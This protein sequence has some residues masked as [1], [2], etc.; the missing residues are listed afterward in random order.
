M[1]SVRNEWKERGVVVAVKHR[2]ETQEM[3]TQIALPVQGTAGL[4]VVIG[5][6]PINLAENPSEVV[7]K[8]VIAYSF[9]EAQRQLGYSDDFKNYSLC[10]SMDA[11]FRIFSIAPIIFINVL[12]PEKHKKEYTQEGITVSGK[13]ATIEA[14]GLMMDSLEIKDQENN[15][16][17][18]D[19][20]YMAV[21][22]ASGGVDVTLLSTDKTVSVTLLSVTGM[23][24]DP[25][26]VSEEDI[27]GGYDVKMG[28]ETGLELIRQVYSRFHFPPGL[29]IA[30]GWSHK[31]AVAAVMCAKTEGINAVFCCE[32]AIDMDAE[33]TKVYTDLPEAKEEMAV[34]NHHAILLWPKLRLGKKVYAFSA[35]WAA[36]TAYTDARNGDVP[37]KSPSNELLGVSATVLED[38]TEVLLDTLMAESVNAAGIVTAINDGGWKAWGNYTAA[39]MKTSDPKDQWI[40]CRRMMSWYRNHFILT[41]KSKVD[42]PLSNVL[43][44]SI[45]D[46]ENLYLNSLTATGDIAGGMIT[47]DEAENPIESI[48]EG[49]IIFRT[50]IAFW[51][52]A[53]YI[54]NKIEFDPTILKTALGVE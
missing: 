35:V 45:V 34:N 16:L 5:T 19:E 54:L 48:L 51:T 31:P 7:N 23:Q 28:K 42:D 18:A 8:P 14:A 39:Y 29:I 11:S 22:N 41:F 4:Q 15:T 17:N 43:I 38:G 6:A 9:A 40:A 2:I 10:Q 20:D 24:L 25:S 47:Y 52:P 49:K 32:T 1:Y 50:K 44:E 53:Q 13:I 21:F 27:I 30:P 36:M 37:V 12:D 26:K 33:L 3:D 46:G